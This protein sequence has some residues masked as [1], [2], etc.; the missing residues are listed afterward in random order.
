MG[1]RIVSFRYRLSR[2]QVTP[3]LIT[4]LCYEIRNI[5]RGSPESNNIEVLPVVAGVCADLLLFC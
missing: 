5:K 3:D 4:H 2:T 1:F